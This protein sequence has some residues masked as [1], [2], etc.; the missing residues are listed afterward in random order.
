MTKVLF[1]FIALLFVGLAS[2]YAQNPSDTIAV[3]KNKFYYHGMQIESM[4]QIKSLVANDEL[5]L[6]EVKKGSVAGGF[7]Y[8]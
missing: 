8:V 4:R 6:K 1:S 7:G 2:T 5:A 3:E